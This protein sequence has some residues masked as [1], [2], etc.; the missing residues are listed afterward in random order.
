[1]ATVRDSAGCEKKVTG[2]TISEPP[3]PFTSADMS[4]DIICPESSATITIVD[5]RPEITYT[6]YDAPTEGNQKA[7][8][9]GNGTQK[10]MTKAL[11]PLSPV[12][13]GMSVEK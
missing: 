7:S 4:A 13:D 2:I 11:V 12:R 6:I 10:K 3:V 9:T 8:V 5:T 1:L